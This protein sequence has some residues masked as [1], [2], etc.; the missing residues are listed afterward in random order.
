MPHADPVAKREYFRQYDAR[1]SYA[2]RAR[3][4]NQ[5]AEAMGLPGRIT[6]DDISHV[7]DGA[8]CATCSGGPVELD[9]II[10]LASGGAN[11]RENLQALCD[12]CN[13]RKLTKNTPQSWSKWSDS[14]LA[15]GT[16]D[17]KHAARGLCYPCY[18]REKYQRKRT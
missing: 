2:Q 9:H 14:C 6:A 12:S 8:V 17:N 7:L 3:L 5:R 13:S 16:V 15:C 4:H 1:R 18:D 10:P 11:A